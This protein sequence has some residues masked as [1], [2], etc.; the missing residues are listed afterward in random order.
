MVDMPGCCQQT[1]QAL[2]EI[3]ELELHAI[4]ADIPNDWFAEGDRDV[5]AGLLAR[6]HSR[7]QRLESLLRFEFGTTCFSSAQGALPVAV[8]PGS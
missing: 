8:S 5:L 7:T 2:Q 1:L 4:V 3:S 6:V